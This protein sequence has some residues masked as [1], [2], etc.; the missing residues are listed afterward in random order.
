MN[1]FYYPCAGYDGSVVKLMASKMNHFLFVDQNYDQLVDALNERQGHPF[2]GYDHPQ[3]VPKEN[4]SLLADLIGFK[5]EIEFFRSA[6]R[7]DSHGLPRFTVT[8]VQGDGI[9]VLNELIEKRLWPSGVACIRPGIS[10][11]G[12]RSTY[13]DELAHALSHFP[14][15]PQFYIRD[16]QDY[17]Y[18]LARWEQENYRITT[19]F[20]AKTTYLQ[21]CRLYVR[22]RV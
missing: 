22:S 14:T 9:T 13:A 8:F 21:A 18:L 3:F 6:N 17:G 15:P 10:F 16:G 7:P 5:K 20:V 4:L 2:L 12:N 19:E 1:F 11:G